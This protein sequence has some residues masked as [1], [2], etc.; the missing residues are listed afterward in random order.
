MRSVANVPFAP[1]ESS[2]EP[3]RPLASSHRCLLVGFV[4]PGQ[5][6][7]HGLLG[8]HRS[9]RGP[10]Q[11]WDLVPMIQL[12]V[13]G[14][15]RAEKSWDWGLAR[16]A[17][18]CPLPC[19]PLLERRTRRHSPRRRGTASQGRIGPVRPET[20]RKMAGLR[21][22][23]AGQGPRADW[24][25]VSSSAARC[26]SKGIDARSR[27]VVRPGTS[28]HS[29]QL[30]ARR[31][32]DLYLLLD[33]D[34]GVA[35]QLCRPGSADCDLHAFGLLQEVLA[36]LYKFA[37]RSG[38]QS[39]ARPSTVATAARKGRGSGVANPV[40]CSGKT[41]HFSRSLTKFGEI[42]GSVRPSV[43]AGREERG[44]KQD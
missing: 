5:G 42:C 20:D 1:G 44:G 8:A 4:R 19:W 36:R 16:V 39:A 26:F 30:S 17:T 7:E 28:S 12:A 21:T 38:G 23:R 3:K 22:P 43:P 24:P 2:S 13:E 6:E 37:R 18:S 25:S 33:G 40:R 41:Q 10:I 9:T 11:T 27:E 31:N 29:Q 32:V 15:D 14:L 35:D 34:A